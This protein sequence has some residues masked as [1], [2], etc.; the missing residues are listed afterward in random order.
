MK[1]Y[2]S[3][4]Q[5]QIPVYGSYDLVVVGAGIAGVAAAVS[6]ARAGLSVCL[7][8]KETAPGGLA[9]LGL[10][11]YYLPLCDG[12]GRKV[13]SGIPEELLHISV[14]YG[15]GEV[16]DCWMR[17]ASASERSLSRY[18]VR[19]NPASFI[20]AIEELLLKENVKMLYDSRCC[21]CVIDRG[22]IKAIIIENKEGRSALCG[23]TFIDATGDADLCA[24]AKE[25]T[26]SL[27]SNLMAAWF[28]SFDKS[29]IILNHL[30]GSSEKIPE[31]D[32]KTYSGTSSEDLTD[33]CI[34]SRI[35]I[36][37]HLKNENTN[38]KSAFPISLPSIPQFRK[39]RRLKG[40]HEL[41]IS[42]NGLTHEDDI[43]L[44]GDWRK[45]GPVFHIPY[46]SLTGK[47]ENLFASGRCISA[48]GEAWDVTR[49]I[50]VCAATGEAAGAAAAI[51]VKTGRSARQI[52]INQLKKLLEEKGVILNRQ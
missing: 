26:V 35:T 24:F 43:C 34:S 30:G 4:D 48:K 45:A 5:R 15:P 11:A 1:K 40:L 3:E 16:P 8:E 7:L 33:F 21:G 23:K 28:Y 49:A 18:M 13:I 52:E 29:E 44:A 12:M 37:Q 46:R 17:E 27:S 51:C 25:E 42:E 2:F 41:D 36:L 38:F 47:T 39:T 22:S 31:E 6:A 19:F 50:P 10:I 9:T 20:I 14:K 32:E